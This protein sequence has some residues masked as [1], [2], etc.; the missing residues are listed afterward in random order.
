LLLEGLAQ[1]LEVAP[2][3]EC[4]I[5]NTCS[6]ADI[7]KISARIPCIIAVDGQINGEAATRY[8]EG[9]FDALG[10]G[11]SYREAHA[12]GK[13]AVGAEFRAIKLKD[14]YQYHQESGS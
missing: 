10:N 13:R 9:F 4:L 1:W 5:L 7:F 14:N 8:A 6:S 11:K 3:L 2:S 12:G